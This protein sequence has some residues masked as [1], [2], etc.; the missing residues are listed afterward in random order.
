M[1]YRKNTRMATGRVLLCFTSVGPVDVGDAQS[2]AFAVNASALILVQPFTTLIGPDMF[3]TLYL[4]INPGTK[5]KH[6]LALF[7]RHVLLI[8]N[9]Y[10][11]TLNLLTAC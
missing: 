2:A 6:Y 10:I 11:L 8:N 7:Q 1:D 4:H 5:L 3:P 9:I